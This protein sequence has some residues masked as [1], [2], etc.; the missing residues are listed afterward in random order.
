V[1]AE[2]QDLDGNECLHTLA[3]TVDV[4]SN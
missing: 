2:M 1:P 4:Y 3:H